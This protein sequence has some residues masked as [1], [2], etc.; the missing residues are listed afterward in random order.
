MNKLILFMMTTFLLSMPV[1]AAAGSLDETFT[2]NGV[3]FKMVAVEGGTFM[4]GNDEGTNSQRP[5]HE[6]TLTGYSI[7]ETEVT[8]ELWLAVMGYNP[9]RYGSTSAIDLQ[10]PVENVTWEM[11]QE[12]I[13]VLNGLTGLEFRLPSEAEWEFAARGGNKSHGYKYAGSD[14][15]DEVAW[16]KNNTPQSYEKGTGTQLVKTKAP[17][18]LGLYDMSGNVSEYCQDWYGAY[19]ANAV[20]DPTGPATGTKRVLRGGYWLNGQ[21]LCITTNRMQVSTLEANSF[22]GFRLAL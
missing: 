22:Y 16:Y 5:A 8:Q 13:T 9:S 6:V 11:C 3:S 12:F 17:N 1:L 20:A 4:M 2:V 15:T 21:N 7:G 18:E 10:R 19:T 14:E